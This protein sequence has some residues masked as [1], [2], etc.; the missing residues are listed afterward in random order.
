V[1]SHDTLINLNLFERIYFFLQ[2][3]K[4]YTGVPLTEESMELL[5]KI[6]AQLVSI[7]ALTAKAMTERISE[8]IPS[9]YLSW[10]TVNQNFFGRG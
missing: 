4:T 8:L 1:T 3:W 5:G 2:R 7:L 6:M 9:L 10:L